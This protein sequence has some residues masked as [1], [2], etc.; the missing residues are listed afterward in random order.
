M[1]IVGG[2]PE[3]K[4]LRRIWQEKRLQATVVWREDISQAELAQE[5]ANC[6]V[7]CLPSVQEGFGIVFL[8]A[9][10]HGKPIVACKAGSDAGGGAAWGVDASGRCRAT[11][12]DAIESL[13]RNAELRRSLGWAGREAVKRF[14][15]PAV[16]RE[17]LWQLRRVRDSD[18]KVA[19]RSSI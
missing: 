1:R 14:G 6:D 12:P 17:F 19:P 10:A 4:R 2:G 9:M 5:Y 13:F 8:E 16:A 11:W 3:R 18:G 15:A 7:F